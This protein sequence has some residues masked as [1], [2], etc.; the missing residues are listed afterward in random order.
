MNLDALTTFLESSPTARLLKADLAA[1]VVYFLR[2]ALP[3]VQSLLMDGSVFDQF[4]DLAT[5]GNGSQTRE[6]P[7]LSDDE[8]ACYE[9]VCRTNRRIEQEHL[10]MQRLVELLQ[11]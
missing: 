5:A 9:R 8:Q 10:P 1:Y 2:Q 4:Q 3:G 7:H 11:V 6:L